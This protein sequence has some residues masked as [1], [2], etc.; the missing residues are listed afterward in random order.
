MSKRHKLNPRISTEAEL[1]G[2]D[3]VIPEFLWS[4]YFIEAQGFEVKDTV[5]YQDNLS[6]ML[7][8]NNGRL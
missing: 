6:A 4:R 1:M 2:A 7:I 5:M 3:N 8:E